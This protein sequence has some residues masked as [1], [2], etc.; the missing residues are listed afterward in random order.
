[1]SDKVQIVCKG[2]E[3]TLAMPGTP[4][5]LVN[6]KV[7]CPK[8]QMKFIARPEMIRVVS[9][10]K[11]ADPV[12]TAAKSVPTRKPRAAEEILDDVEI[13]DDDDDLPEIPAPRSSRSKRAA[14]EIDD[15]DDFELPVSPKKKKDLKP[16]K[17]VKKAPTRSYG[18]AV[19]LWTLGGIVGGFIGGGVWWTVAYLTGSNVWYLSVL[20]GTA[21]GAGVRLGAAQYEGLMPA[22]TAVFI[23]LVTL[24]SSKL[25]LNY[26]L[27]Y[28]DIGGIGLGETATV[29]RMANLTEEEMVSEYITA[30]VEPEYRKQGKPVDHPRVDD[31]DY[32][33]D[34]DKGMYHPDLWKDA[35]ARW[36]AMPPPEQAA[37][38]Q[39]LLDQQLGI[40]RKSL[41]YRIIEKEVKPEFAQQ[42]KRVELNEQELD[43]NDYAEI[44]T[45]ETLQEATRRLDAQTPEQ[46]AA[47]VES[48][49]AER[50]VTAN[51][52][53]GV[54]IFMVF[55]YT[56]LGFLWPG[57]LIC[58]ILACVSAYQ[59]GNYDGVTT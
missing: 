18:A 4:E 57:N 32:E 8:C 30:V 16:K 17:K 27:Y 20:M 35:E 9:A 25:A 48:I 43:A 44:Y 39:N 41:L 49:K 15:D 55:A 56:I 24:F 28:D 38:R 10:T 19:L 47:L 13:L 6:R 3:A 50:A 23:T 7:R 46:R 52:F 37:F 36:R 12:K 33:D 21:V 59:I 34:T 1:M 26:T 22:L 42:N 2:C 11:P 51:A 40:D 58:L 45:E 14:Q 5:A 29:T 31:E 54:Q 53:A